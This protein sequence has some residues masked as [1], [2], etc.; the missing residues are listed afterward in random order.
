MR[1][2]AAVPRS[3]SIGPLT[4]TAVMAWHAGD[5]ALAND[6][7]DRILTLDPGLTLARILTRFVN[8]GHRPGALA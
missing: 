3:L 2:T 8:L 4:L 6:A 5:G 1:L 7:L